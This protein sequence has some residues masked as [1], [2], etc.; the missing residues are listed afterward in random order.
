MNSAKLQ[1][2]KLTQKINC[3]FSIL[4][5]NRHSGSFYHLAVGNSAAVNMSVQAPLGDAAFNVL[6][7]YPEVGWLADTAALFLT[8]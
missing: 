2:I 7:Q 3:V 1:D 8:F 6:D 4:T 5:I